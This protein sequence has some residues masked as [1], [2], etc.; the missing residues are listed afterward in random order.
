VMARSNLVAL[1]MLHSR[2]VRSGWLR[3]A[4]AGVCGAMS[5]ALPGKIAAG[6]PRKYL[7]NLH[8]ENHR[9]WK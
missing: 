3:R 9:K 5:P 7:S 8:W 1:S 6:K 4:A 2:G